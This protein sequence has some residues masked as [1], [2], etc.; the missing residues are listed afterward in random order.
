MERA[1][2]RLINSRTSKV[3]GTVVCTPPRTTDSR[4]PDWR[5]LSAEIESLQLG[6]TW[7]GGVFDVE[8]PGRIWLVDEY[9]YMSHYL[10]AV[11]RNGR[12]QK[13]GI[14]GSCPKCGEQGKFVRMALVCGSHGAYA[15]L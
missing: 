2:Y 7:A 11:D 1:A 4:S 14:D 13:I 15:G 3:E 6:R 9:G 8:D 10:D 12:V 5:R